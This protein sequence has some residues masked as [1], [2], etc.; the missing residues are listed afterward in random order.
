MII[1]DNIVFELQHVGGVSKSWAKNVERLDCMNLD[2]CFLEGRKAKNN[3]FRRDLQLTHPVI[4][5]K[6]PAII[7]RFQKIGRL[8]DVFHSSYY[9]ISEKAKFNVVTIHDF[10]NEM[11]PSNFRD[12]ILAALKRRACRYADRIIVVSEHTRQDLLHHYPDLDP[13]IVEVVYNG[14]DEEF[15]P[16]PL[17][18]PIQV[19]SYAIEP[20]SYFLYV[21]TRG[22]CKNFS[23]TLS[24]LAQA[25]SQG[26]E[27]RLVI[28]GG[29]PFSGGERKEINTLGLPEDAILQLSDVNSP[30]LRKLYSNT[31]ALLIPSIYEGFGLP[32]LEA[33]R[34]GT[35]VLAA[36]GSALEEIVGETDYA[37]DLNRKGEINRIIAL[38]FDNATAS[39]ERA[40]VL[41][42]STMFSWDNSVQRLAEIYD[43]LDHR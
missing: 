13:G 10:M 32:A 21:G 2:I 18:T 26:L 35:L 1:C 33:A 20:K 29:G 38:G 37:I 5:D 9:R 12:P 23:Y 28:V 24:F 17:T 43:D 41:K 7:R 34:C 11:Y 22:Y 14:V 31:V 19:Q 40:R 6:G 30:T 3:L 4:F 27:H 39:I 15:Y 25:R 36:R 8:T 16:E 42:R